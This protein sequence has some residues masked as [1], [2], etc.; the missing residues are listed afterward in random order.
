MVPFIIICPCILVIM[1]NNTT[2]VGSYCLF[3]VLVVTFAPSLALRSGVNV[4]TRAT[5]KQYMPSKNHVIALFA[6]F[7]RN[8]R[9][10][11]SNIY[12]NMLEC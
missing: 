10:I 2:F 1:N 11:A 9:F 7:F 4:T 5:N 8:D 6:I 3:V 12:K